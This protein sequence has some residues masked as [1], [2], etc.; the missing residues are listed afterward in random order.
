M[1]AENSNL[2][3][4]CESMEAEMAELRAQIMQYQQAGGGDLCMD[5]GSL[6]DEILMVTPPAAAD[7]DGDAAAAHPFAAIRLC[8]CWAL[9]VVLAAGWAAALR[10]LASRRGGRCLSGAGLPFGRP[11]QPLSRANGAV[12]GLPIHGTTATFFF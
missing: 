1:R 10:G 11:P 5:G 9:L 2:T 7:E 3:R 6:L 4:Q 12:A 8:G